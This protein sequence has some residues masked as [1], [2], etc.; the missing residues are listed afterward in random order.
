MSGSSGIGGASNVERF[1]VQPTD[2]GV[3][4]TESAP[5]A[6]A[7]RAST[8]ASGARAAVLASVGGTTPA[9]LTL[10]EGVNAG[11]APD[12]TLVPTR[13][14]ASSPLDVLTELA[15]TPTE[16]SGPFSSIANADR[17]ILSAVAKKLGETHAG[18]TGE[19]PDEATHLAWR[20]GRAATLNLMEAAAARAF[21]LGDKKLARKILR[22]LTT[23]IKQEPWRQVRDFACESLVSR[24]EAKELPEVKAAREAVYPSRPP[25]DKWL[26]NGRIDIRMYVDDSGSLIKDNVD[27]YK[28]IGFSHQE[29]P[30][31][32]HTLTRPEDDW[33]AEVQI[34][35]PPKQGEPAL[36]EKMDDPNVDVIT[37]AGHAGYGHRVDHAISEG[38]GGAGEDKLVI[39]LQCW[40][41]GNVESLER[42][43]PEAQMLSTTAMTDDNLDFTLMDHLIE[44]FREK[45]TWKQMERSAESTLKRW[46]G[47]DSDYSYTNMDS[48]YFYPT[49]RSTLVNKY[50]RDGD[51]K[52]DANDHIFNVI[53]PKRSDAAGGYDPVVQPVPKYALD[54]TALT[55]SLSERRALGPVADD[56]LQPPAS[57]RRRGKP[58]V[59]PG[60]VEAR[61]LLR[62][63]GGRP[64]SVSV[65]PNGRGERR[66][67]SLYALRAHPKGR[68]RPHARLRDRPVAR[69]GG[70]ARGRRPSGV[71]RRV[72]RAHGAP[73]VQLVRVAGHPRRAGSRGSAAHEPLRARGFHLPRAR[74]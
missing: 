55:G 36:F 29:N 25:Y 59:E 19:A 63:G 72:P 7:G 68:P 30:D 6:A 54:G 4:P 74:A 61:R 53:Y 38:V 69:A 26:E 21:E 13:A 52:N 66:G 44:G 22:R 70:W 31:G 24:A 32:S 23:A 49:T 50:D 11:I 33:G 47:N 18:L 27:F 48:H 67:R 40:G 34:T 71:R 65:Q 3:Q 1:D 20:Q 39:L 2:D 5:S 14:G 73:A 10:L 58:P 42:A 28:E 60:R 62:A 43:Y 16:G 17:E 45:K 8:E 35:I 41:E 57:A 12:G 51:G 64:A 37:Y 15:L 46:Y 9:E 56:P